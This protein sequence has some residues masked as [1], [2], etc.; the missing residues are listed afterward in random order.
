MARRH[1][2]QAFDYEI[3]FYSKI[4]EKLISAEFMETLATS[5][6]AHYI[7]ADLNGV[8]CLEPSFW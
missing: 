4:T 6:F 2:Y 1:G 5:K 8:N 7:E 3:N